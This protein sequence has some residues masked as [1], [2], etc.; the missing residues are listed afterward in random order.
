MPVAFRFVAIQWCEIRIPGIIVAHRTQGVRTWVLHAVNVSDI[1]SEILPTAARGRHYRRISPS[2]HMRLNPPTS[3]RKNVTAFCR[4]G[5]RVTERHV[6]ATAA[7]T[8]D[9][10]PD[11]DPVAKQRLVRLHLLPAS[12]AQRVAMVEGTRDCRNDDNDTED[13]SNQCHCALPHCR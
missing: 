8:V 4:T 11:P 2:N 3:P 13:N 12:I 6:D 7:D 1:T 5:E 10:T 9:G